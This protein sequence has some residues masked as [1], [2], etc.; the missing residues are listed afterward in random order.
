MQHVYI[1]LNFRLN[2]FCQ[3]VDILQNLIGGTVFSIKIIV[4]KYLI[5]FLKLP[6]GFHHQ[7]A[8]KDLGQPVKM[9]ISCVGA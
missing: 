1:L 8:A 9:M 5:P 4:I 2:S 3:L 7:R 6:P